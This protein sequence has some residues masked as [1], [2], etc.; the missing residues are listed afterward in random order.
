MT[1]IYIRPPRSNSENE[2][3]EEEPIEEETESEEIA[4]EAA[5]D[6]A[7]R[8]VVIVLFVLAVSPFHFT[9]EHN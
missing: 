2:E 8:L 5:I 3:I 1:F 6:A 4:L 7:R 9:V